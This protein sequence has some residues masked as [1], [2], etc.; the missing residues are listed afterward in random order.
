[1]SLKHKRVI[2]TGGSGGIGRFLAVEFI[3]E[4]AD[5]SLMSRSNDGAPEAHHFKVDLSTPEGI[6]AACQIVAQK[7]P[8]IL[9][10]LAGVQ[11]FGPID[12][13]SLSEM[14][15]GY[16]V[17][18]LAPAALCKA[19]LPDMRRRDD[20]QIINIGSIF[21]SIA[22]AHFA[23]YSSAKAGLRALSEALRRELV[24]TSVSVTHIAPRAVR[25]G[26]L[27]PKMLKFAELTG[28]MSMNPQ[29]SPAK[30]WRPS[31]SAKRTSA[32]AFRSVFMSVSTHFCRGWSMPPSP[33]T[34]AG[35]RACSHRDE[36]CC[37]DEGGGQCLEYGW[38]RLPR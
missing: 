23:T 3:R 19:V 32:S 9:V 24:D 17:N 14:F 28:C 30:S 20:G 21:G 4:G 33:A 13:Q 26:L 31:G 6:S 11:Y 16:M 27:T 2:L 25:T 10:N 7:K 5:L 36:F 35:R 29:P 18:L 15:E 8:D 12:D 37:T 38:R 22:F 34:T 1:M